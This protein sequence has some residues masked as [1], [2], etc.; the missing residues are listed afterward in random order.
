MK[1]VGTRRA[2]GVDGKTIKSNTVILPQLKISNFTLPNVP[3]D[4]ELPTDAQGLSFNILGND[5]LKRF[6]VILDYRE[7]VIYIKPNSLQDALYNKSLDEDMFIMVGVAV[8]IILLVG[9]VIVFRRRLKRKQSKT[10]GVA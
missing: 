5:V 9:F 10:V 8:I 6:N 3:I 1:K 7:G 2:K 4:L